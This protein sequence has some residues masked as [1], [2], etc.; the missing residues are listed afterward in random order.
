MELNN[1]NMELSILVFLIWIGMIIAGFLSDLGSDTK[2][3]FSSNSSTAIMLLL[4]YIFIILT[5]TSS[6]KEGN[7]RSILTGGIP[8]IGDALEYEPVT[9]AQNI[10]EAIILFFNSVIIVIII[11]IVSIFT[12]KNTGFF[13]NLLVGVLLSAISF[14]ITYYLSQN[15]VLH[16]TLIF[17]GM[18]ITCFAIASFVAIILYKDDRESSRKLKWLQGFSKT[19]LAN[20]FRNTALKGIIYVIGLYI[21]R[22]QLEKILPGESNVFEAALKAILMIL[23][24]IVI[25]VIGMAILLRSIKK[26]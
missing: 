12:P 20:L 1:W 6:T 11:Q 4:T 21:L 25:M 19:K 2:N 24:P 13:V 3:S 26:K 18:I 16:I 5:M 7:F 10:Y 22:G 15:S 14:L 9:L 8:I 23:G 17:L